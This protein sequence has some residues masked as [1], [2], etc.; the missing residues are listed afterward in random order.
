MK[1]SGA[2]PVL[3]N[4]LGY[5]FG[6]RTALKSVDL[7][8]DEG[9]ILGLVGPN[10]SGKTTLLKLLAGLLRPRVGTVHVCGYE[11]GRDRERV[12]QR[13]RFA[14]APPALFESLNAREHLRYLGQMSGERP[15]SAAIDG[16]LE[17]VGLATRSRDRVRAYSLGM[18]QRLAL[19]QAL[20]PT[21]ELLVLDEPTEG[22]DP[23]GVLE[24]REVLKR[25]RDERGVT[26]V[27]SS[28][29]LVEVEQLVDSMLVLMNGKV[30]F[31]GDPHELL[32]DGERLVL[33]ASGV[34]AKDLS[35]HFVSSGVEVMSAAGSQLE[36]AAGALDL[37]RANAL[38]AEAGGTLESFHLR[39]P[40]LQS[41]LLE[42]QRSLSGAGASR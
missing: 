39:K 14:F 13:A 1:A 19:A 33:D 3:V 31:N 9:K 32:R 16:V 11:P 21:P 18:R 30:E 35:A 5:R 36:L 29:L 10:G 15:T 25:L 27:L 28:H 38:V 24:L 23:L 8:V 6:K 22:L 20:L 12:M 41:A 17:T 2:P 42:R 34:D 40:D 4:G 26:I 7:R 37:S